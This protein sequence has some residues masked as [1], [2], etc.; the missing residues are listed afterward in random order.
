MATT[1]YKQLIN[2]YRNAKCRNYEHL[3]ILEILEENNR[4]NQGWIQEFS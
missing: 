1:M 4:Y 2:N 3:S